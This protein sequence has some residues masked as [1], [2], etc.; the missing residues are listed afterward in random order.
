MKKNQIIGVIAGAFD[1]IHPGYIYLFNE[2]K[3]HCDH[4]LLLLHED[5]SIERSEKMK[6]ILS[7]KERKLILSSLR[8]IDEIITYKTE[9]DLLKI[10]KNR[11]IDIRFQGDDYKKKNFTGQ[12]LDIPIHFLDR[13]HGWSTTK[14]KKLLS[15][16]I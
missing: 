9:D 15:N 5:P 6:P 16:N 1:V 3:Q 12:E 10:L 4:F 14:F 2:C 7:I 13:S 8:Q 11:K